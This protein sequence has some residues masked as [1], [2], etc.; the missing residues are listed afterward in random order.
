MKKTLLLIMILLFLF[1]C[2]PQTDDLTVFAAASLQESLDAVIAVYGKPVTVT[3]DS[4]G[5][6]KTQIENGADCDVFLS[7]SPKQIEALGKLVQTRVDLLENKVCLAVPEGDPAGIR[8]FDQLARELEHGTV[9]LAIGNADVPVGQYTQKIFTYYNLD[10]TAV[11]DHLT[12]GSNAKEVTTLVREGVVSCGILYATDARTAGLEVVDTATAEM[13]GQVLYP[14]ALL[15]EAG[16]EFLDFL[17]TEEA[18]ACFE[19]AGF[20]VVSQG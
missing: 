13:C 2:A 8:S 3:Y 7:A 12:Y 16:Q 17:Q 9:L 4:S 18:L 14:A 1:G 15:T 5:T 20:S 6:L 11:S 10:E 19:A